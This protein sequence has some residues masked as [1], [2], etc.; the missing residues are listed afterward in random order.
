MLVQEK[1]MRLLGEGNLND[2]DNQSKTFTS[3]VS[4]MPTRFFLASVLKLIYVLLHRVKLKQKPSN[5]IFGCIKKG[6]RQLIG[7]NFV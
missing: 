6:L 1:L 5:V 3:K 7:I 2:G 4:L